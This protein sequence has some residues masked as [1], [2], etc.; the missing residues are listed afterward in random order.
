MSYLITKR[1]IDIHNARVPGYDSSP[2]LIRILR[3][4]IP[5]TDELV[6]LRIGVNVYGKNACTSGAIKMSNLERLM[7]VIE[8]T[9][10]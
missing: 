7:S 3:V 8:E 5:G 4:K 10:R 1:H 9:E 2:T 6:W